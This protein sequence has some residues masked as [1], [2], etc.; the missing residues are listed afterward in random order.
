MSFATGARRGFTL[1]NA[2]AT[3]T[4]TVERRCFFAMMNVGVE[5]VAP[6][7]NHQTKYERDAGDGAGGNGNGPVRS[8]A[9]W[10]ARGAMVEF[11]ALVLSRWHVPFDEVFGNLFDHGEL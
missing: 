11:D 9:T 1:N 10:S 7:G 8:G 2:V 5:H 4:S 3:A 6:K